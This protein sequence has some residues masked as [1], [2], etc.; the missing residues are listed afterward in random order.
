MID[1]LEVPKMHKLVNYT[2]I[3]SK[4]QE[5]NMNFLTVH[6]SLVDG[7]RNLANSD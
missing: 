1:R 7:L 2:A 6:F 3:H 5:N 4:S